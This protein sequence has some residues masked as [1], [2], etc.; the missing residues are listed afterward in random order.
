[1]AFGVGY[2]VVFQQPG[3]GSEC[4]QR[5]A[6]RIVY[7]G[8][9]GDNT[10][11]GESVPHL[12]ETFI[13][14]EIGLIHCEDTGR[15][16]ESVGQREGD[17]IITVF[18]GQEERVRFL[19]NNTESRVVIDRRVC[20]GSQILFNESNESRIACDCGNLRK[21]PVQGIRSQIS[22]SGI[23]D[24]GMLQG[25]KAEGEGEGGIVVE[26]IG[27]L[28]LGREE[29]SGKLPVI[30][31]DSLE[32]DLSSVMEGESRGITEIGGRDPLKETVGACLFCND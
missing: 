22:A 14:Q 19:G 28:F 23:E 3:Q 17:Q 4:F 16:A 31:D 24:Q 20:L 32:R 5:V 13:G 1:M 12:L 30:E 27:K 6:E 15:A 21:F 25:S 26:V 8:R 29:R 18:I 7:P 10:V 9:D 11:R 2:P